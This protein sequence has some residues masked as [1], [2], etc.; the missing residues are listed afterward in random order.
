MHGVCTLYTPDT[1]T[2]FIVL[3]LLLF[4]FDP[5]VAFF[6]WTHAL[7]GSCKVFI[8]FYLSSESWQQ[9]DEKCN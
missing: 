2:Q 3:H 1:S 4:N 5:L 6:S 8:F 9:D 7:V